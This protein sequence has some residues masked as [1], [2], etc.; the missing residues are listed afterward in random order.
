M[1]EQNIRIQA[2]QVAIW[3]IIVGDKLIQLNQESGYLKKAWSEL[4]FVHAYQ[5]QIVKIGDY[6]G[7]PCFLIDMGNEQID[8]DTFALVSMRSILTEVDNAF[9]GIA[10]RAWQV[11]LF[12]RTHRYCGQCGTTMQQVEWEMAMHC[13]RCNH[14]C[15]PRISPC[16]IV[17]IRHK[18]KL[19]LAQGKP[20]QSRQMYSTLAGFVES[21][22]TL[23][24]AVH[25]EVMEEVGVKLSNLR[26][27]NSQPWPF[28][29]SLMVGFLADYL[30]GD[31][32]VDGHE[33]ID[34][35]WFDIDALPV[36]PPT[37]S[38]AGQLIQ[39]TIKEIKLNQKIEP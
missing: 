20:H 9:F 5:E 36:I 15:Y 22:E 29:H 6:E 35:Q 30:E 17:A 32:V 16:I 14:R 2:E 31:I 13:S 21:G 28:P 3:I 18:N 37:F 1:V 23:E 27:F 7:H 39:H 8:D 25:R 38:I 33:I 11:A 10:A 19:L 34:A 26:Y 4:S 12:M 24:E